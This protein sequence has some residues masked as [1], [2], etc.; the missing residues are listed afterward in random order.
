VFRKLDAPQFLSTART[1]RTFQRD[2]FSITA[3][4]N[5]VLLVFL[6][7]FLIT[8]CQK[9]ATPPPNQIRAISR[10]FV[11]AARNGS[12]GRAEVGMVPEFEERRRGKAEALVEDHIYITVPLTS[13]GHPDK[14]MQNAIQKEMAR[15]AEFHHLKLAVRPVEHGMETFDY[16]SNGARTHAVHFI[17]PISK[18]AMP[19][20][21]AAKS[22][23][24]S[25]GNPR[26]NARLAIVIDDLGND[27]AQA[28]FL[29]GL[30]YPLSLSVLPNTPNSM[31]IATEAHQRGYEVLLHLPMAADNPAQ[32]ETVELRPGMSADAV[33][34]AFITMLGDVPFATGV[35]NHE[36][37]SGTSN[38]ALMDNLMPLLRERKLFF[39]D[40]R[41]SPTSV[42]ETEAQRAGVPA[43]SRNVFL[44]DVQS[45]DA[46]RKQFALAVMDARDKGSAL[47]I[48][49]PHSTTLQVLAEELPDL[50]RQGISLVFASSLVR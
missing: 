7:V 13:S 12:D 4:Q 14:A 1:F 32:D 45:P 24:N 17:T 16:V 46:I 8:G 42:A 29:F 49:H 25:A 39:I 18:P 37:S 6:A 5:L 19:P 10:E 34:K 26:S 9:K 36:G 31:Q 50:K 28:E 27:H 20:A 43:A 11:L 44:D 3:S 47:A 23:V 33:S 40:S 2:T 15:V 41:T 21:L 30:D 48:G 38:R 22:R 35:N